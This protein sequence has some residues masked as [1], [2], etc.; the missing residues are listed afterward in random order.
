MQHYLGVEKGKEIALI[1]IVKLTQEF[2]E[3]REVAFY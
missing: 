2:E 3:T 1:K